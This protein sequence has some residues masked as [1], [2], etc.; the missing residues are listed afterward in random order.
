MDIADRQ[1]RRRDVPVIVEELKANRSGVAQSLAYHQSRLDT[2]RAHREPGWTPPIQLFSR[3]FVFPAQLDR[4]AW[5]SA[6]E[7]GTL[8]HIPYDDVLRMARVYAQQARYEDQTRTVGQIIY[9]R[10]YDGG[11]G[12]VLEN[13]RNLAGIIESFRYREG[14]LIATYDSV[15]AAVAPRAPRR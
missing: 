10:L 13:H 5:S 12:A 9:A 11:R 14:E 3:G 15:L 2:M 7:T 4:T 1:V 6:S 8:S